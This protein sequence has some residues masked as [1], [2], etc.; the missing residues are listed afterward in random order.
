[1]R[2][3]AQP[4]AYLWWLVSRAS[5]I[6]A[7]VLIS[8]SVVLG[9]AMAGK[10]ISRPRLRQAVAKLH[11]HV[12]VTAVLAIGAHGISLL[13]DHWLNPGLAGIS[14]PFAMSYRPTFT[15]IGIIGGY[16]ALLLGP[17]FY[18]RRRIGARRW[19]TLHRFIL[20]VWVLSAIHA[21]GSGSDAPRLWLR[22]LVVVPVV[23]VAYLLVV[24][25]L[26]PVPA[27]TVPAHQP[28]APPDPNQLASPGREMERLRASKV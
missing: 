3:G 25:A 12:A 11:E 26:R 9:L 21:L 17:T 24:R 7:L 2:G 1:M 14:I 13:G 22:G 15:G 28:S 23:P 16:L 27:R 18:L 6:V 8:V 5:G 10:A 4:V 19:R 20:A